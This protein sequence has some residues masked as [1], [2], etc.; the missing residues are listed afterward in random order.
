MEVSSWCKGA[1]QTNKR[2]VNPC[3]YIKDFIDDPVKWRE[4]VLPDQLVR[5][6]SAPGHYNRLSITINY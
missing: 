2:Q 1:M 6:T 4:A 3:V 5:C